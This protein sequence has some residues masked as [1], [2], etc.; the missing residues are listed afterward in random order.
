MTRIAVYGEYIIPIGLAACTLSSAVGSIMVAPR[1]LQA[2][3]IDKNI[4]FPKINQFL[5]KGKG[6]K[7]EPFN[8][9]LLSVC[10]AF[11]F[12]ALGNM[13]AVAGI[14]T[15]FF[16]ITYGTLCLI[17]FLNHFGSSPS[18]RP[19]FKS[20]WYFSLGGFI[21]SVW[22]MFKINSI[23]TILAYITIITIYLFIE[24]ANKHEKGIVSIF[25]GAFIPTE[26]IITCLPAKRQTDMTEND[27]W[28]PAAICISP[29]SFERSKVL[30]LMKWISH[31]HGFGPIFH[32]IEGYYCKQ[33]HAESQ[34]ILRQLIQTQ[35][36]HRSALYIDTMISPSYT[37]AI[38]Q[39]IQ[40]P[41]ISGMENN[42]VIFEYDKTKPE[43]LNR[44]LD[45]INL[46]GREF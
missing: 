41:S 19:R 46:D 45:N 10:I 13:N 33:T 23:Y 30:E 2:I 3:A 29:N 32:F 26:P 1:I 40:T 36:G 8:A 37:S 31:Q 27:E 4:P 6:E 14:I 34:E 12:V 38:A 43:E 44:I 42:M 7:N 5:A 22:V 18:Y 17:S 35:H 24:H 25:R 15:M 16:L 11:I 39:V 21:L 28:R 20:K 9:T